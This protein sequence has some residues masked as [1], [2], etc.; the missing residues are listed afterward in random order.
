MRSVGVAAHLAGS[1]S[2]CLQPCLWSPTQYLFTALA[3][4]LRPRG[5]AA[6]RR[7]RARAPARVPA[8]AMHGMPRLTRRRLPPLPKWLNFFL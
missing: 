6:Q 8:G 5:R 2:A 1:A 4:S 3:G 7:A